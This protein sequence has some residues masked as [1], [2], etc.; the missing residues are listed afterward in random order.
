MVNVHLKNA[1]A[2]GP[3]LVNVHQAGSNERSS[4]KGNQ[5]DGGNC[6]SFEFPAIEQHGRR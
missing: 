1:I 3:H 4:G 6:P 2:I 5:G